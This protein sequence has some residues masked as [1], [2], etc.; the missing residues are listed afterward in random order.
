M[1]NSLGFKG[2]LRFFNPAKI[3]VNSF[4]EQGDSNC[5]LLLSV[6]SGSNFRELSKWGLAEP[7]CTSGR[8]SAQ[9]LAG[10]LSTLQFALP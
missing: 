8:H 5:T 7:K 2:S 6:N 1:V 9:T 10:T 3:I 4:L